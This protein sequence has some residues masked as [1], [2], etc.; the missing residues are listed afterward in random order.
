MSVFSFYIH[1]II[2][3]ITNATRDN[4]MAIPSISQWHSGIVLSSPDS[5]AI[6]VFCD[7]IS[8][9]N[10]DGFWRGSQIQE[11]MKIPQFSA[12]RSLYFGNGETVSV[13]CSTCVTC[14]LVKVIPAT[15]N[16]YL[17]RRYCINT[18]KHIM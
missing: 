10:S 7:L 16:H 4:D 5:P 14:E 9:Q 8:L 2:I 17:V 12:N 11:G 13:L 3:I 18:A 6:L 1:C 15:A